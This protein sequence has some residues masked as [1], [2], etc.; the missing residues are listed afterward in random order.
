MQFF[1]AE[2]AYIRKDGHA[3]FGQMNIAEE[4]FILASLIA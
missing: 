1:L 2:H 4:D 3:S